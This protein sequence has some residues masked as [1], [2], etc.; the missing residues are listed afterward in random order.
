MKPFKTYEEQMKILRSRNLQVPDEAIKILQDEN[1]YNVINGYSK[2]FLKKDADNKIL[3][4]EIYKNN[5]HI[6]EVYTLFKLDRQ[7]RNIL[8]EYLL[9]FES[10][11]K[12]RIAYHFSEEFIEPHSYLYFKNYSGDLTKTNSILKT[13]STLSHTMTNNKF[14]AVQHYIKTHDG[15]PL[16]VLINYLTIGNVNHLY[17][18]LNDKV[19][20]EIAK[21]YSDKV[22]EQHG[23]I[24]ERLNITF[25]VNPKDIDAI[26]HQVN[27]YRNVCAHEEILYNFKIIK[28][29]SL[30][31]IFIGSNYLTGLSLNNPGNKTYF[32]HF[33]Y[34][35]KLFL[36]KKDFNNMV[37]RIDGAFEKYKHKFKSISV[38]DI[39]IKM[40]VPSAIDSFSKLK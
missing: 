8:L 39:Y 5:T 7:L 4:P 35:L 23:K 24:I 16:W 30:K 33:I 12:S 20:L 36:N 32:F 26:L 19:R 3:K 15:V 13:I 2:I 27:L 17:H 37:D 38:S 10:N 9:V 18:N 22:L 34:A 1:Y 6:E 25:Q 29:T 28:A 31:N 40:Q 14:Q 11:I 21:S